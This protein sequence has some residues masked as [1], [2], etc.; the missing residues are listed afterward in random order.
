MALNPQSEDT[1]K[2]IAASLA[3]RRQPQSPAAGIQ[4]IAPSR[5]FSEETPI[6]APGGGSPQDF[7]LGQGIIDFLSAGT[8]FTAG[9]GRKIGQNIESLRQGDNM[10]ALDLFNPISNIKGGI[11]GINDRRTWSEN[12]A[13]AGMPEGGTAIEV[14]PFSMNQRDTAGLALDIILDPLWL[15]PGGAI[16]AAAKGTSKGVALASGLST[17][18]V[19]LTKD[20]VTAARNTTENFSRPLLTD[21]ITAGKTGVE[22][23][24]PIQEFFPQT[25]QKIPLI[26]K[27]GISNLINGVR[28]STADEY[29]RWGVARANRRK[30]TPEET[31]PFDQGPAGI[32]SSLVKPIDELDETRSAAEVAVRQAEEVVDNA[33]AARTVADTEKDFDAN[34]KTVEEAIP[35]KALRET[36]REELAP[37]KTAFITGKN[38]DELSIDFDKVEVSPMAGDMADV[39]NRAVNTIDDPDT[40]RAYQDLGNEAREQYRYMTEDLGVRVEYVREDPYNINGVPSSKLMMEDVQKNKRLQ[41]RDSADDFATNPHPLWDVETN[42][43]FRA[44]HDFFG[45]AGS[46]R[47]F[48]AAGEEAAWLSHSQMFSPLARRAMTTETRGQNS[49]YNK[50]GEFAPQ[51]TFLFPEE[52]V[53]APTQ[54]AEVERRISATNQFIGMKSNALT[55]YSDQLI[56]ELAMVW[57][58]IRQSKLY[59]AD[60]IKQIRSKYAELTDLGRYDAKTPEAQGTIKLFDELEKYLTTPSRYASV[61]RSSGG[62]SVTDLLRV[63][64]EALDVEGVA[65]QK[66]A[67]RA[68]AMFRQILDEPVD[69]TELLE[70]ALKLENRVI[71]DPKPFRPTIWGAPAQPGAVTKAP[72]SR[73]KLA[74]YFPDDELLRNDEQLRLAMGE[75]KFK[76]GSAGSKKAA[77]QQQIIWDNFRSRNHDYMAEVVERERNDWFATNSTQF[78]EFF[79]KMPDG[80]VVGQ[81]ALPAAIPR[82]TI[83]TLAGRPMTTLAKILDNLGSVINRTG[84][85]VGG[86]PTTQ[87]RGGAI[88]GRTARMDDVA[89]SPVMA[90]GAIAAPTRKQ[91]ITAIRKRGREIELDSYPLATQAWLIKSLDGIKAKV[92]KEGASDARL[93]D[94]AMS[95]E[96]VSTRLWDELPFMKSRADATKIAKLGPEA[97]VNLSKAPARQYFID[98]PFSREIGRPDES[99]ISRSAST[100]GTRGEAPV[101]ARDPES[102]QPIDSTGKPVPEKDAA[103]VGGTQYRV[104]AEGGKPYTGRLAARSGSPAAPQTGA[105]PQQLA[106]LQA[107]RSTV[108]AINEAITGKTLAVTQ[109]QSQLLAS[110]LNT[111]Q[112]RVA[113]NATPSKIFAQFKQEALPRFEE[114]VARIES[115]AKIES[116]A[117]HS[118][119]IFKVVDDESISLMKAIE[120]Y[121]VG[122]LQLKTLKFTEDAMQLVDDTCRAGARGVA[123]VNNLPAGP[124]GQSVLDRV[125]GGLSG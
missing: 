40:I 10:A 22:V 102:G 80:T 25:G 90:G 119:A 67:E 122:D 77:T 44:V 17:G 116:V 59:S 81:G 37:A 31:K 20:A 74:Q 69:A 33:P 43:I 105:G 120:D 15:I 109:E 75:T 96:N 121:D 5:F 50:F 111:L 64:S 60:E 29:A 57:T 53:L 7:S 42:N 1:Y 26:S 99:G 76:P 63:A 23:S 92:A 123:T 14:G 124:A 85:Q 98:A 108:G 56:E 12:L 118:K 66:T 3:A 107:I 95:V 27:D 65:D 83:Y 68:L 41:V 24:Q 115:A 117:Y 46:G 71:S 55:E 2:R 52:Y 112:I 49:Y 125:L 72:F 13:D 4:R 19:K 89:G 30:G 58:P 94:E 39:Y 35:T 106:G 101:V 78:S 93:M 32:L 36:V 103:T 100:T 18:G 110:V 61:A 73:D 97:I 104:L 9:A 34:A 8:Y 28:Y 70:N 88:V 6:E 48:D 38:L 79:T 91:I 54:F 11:D 113:D 86:L 45:H 51:K 114:I 47:G 84:P 82:G 62:N 21:N 16:A 87:I